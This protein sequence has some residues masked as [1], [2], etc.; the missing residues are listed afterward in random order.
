MVLEILQQT[1]LGHSLQDILIALTILIGAY[2]LG[3]I[4]YYFFK[5]IGRKITAKTKTDLDDVLIDI[6][7]EPIAAVIFLIG[8][9]ISANYLGI[10][11]GLFSTVFK[12]AVIIVLG[13]T[14]IRFVDAFRDKILIP[15]TKK[16]KSSFDD[17]MV[18]LFS[19]GSKA[20]IIILGTIMLLDSVG[21]DVTALLA[22][23]GIGGLALAFAAQETVSN[24]FGGIALLLDKS[25]KLGDKIKLDS[26]EIGII[27]EVGLRSTRVRTYSNEVIIVPNSTMANSKII[28]YAQPNS[29]GRGEIKFGVSYGTKP[30]KVQ[31]TII[32]LIKNHPMVSK[33]QG[34]EPAVE[35][36]SMGD[37]SLNFTAKFWCDNYTEVWST[38]RE[39][40]KE[41]YN[42]LNKAKISIPFP[43]HTVYLQK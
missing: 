24:L 2:A 15:L 36:L 5:T 42:E 13:W 16:T 39:L 33:K 10:Q 7:E 43:T 38:E 4:A 28:N 23:V 29:F 1:F 17:Q 9:F 40:T 25:I 18:P 20:V 32:N 27:E 19:K 8:A 6:I 12:S 31:K 22:G 35:M 34:R 41:I 14:A 21:F 11:N 30:E 26:G 3:K 37:F